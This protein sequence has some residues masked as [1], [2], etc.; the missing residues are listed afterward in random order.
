MT[1]TAGGT[2]A[3]GEEPILAR[4][5]EAGHDVGS[6][7]ELRGSGVKYP[8]AVPVLV[9]ALAVTAEKKALMEVVRALSVPWARTA[10]TG[11]LIDL[12]Q[13]ADDPTGLGLRW[14]VGNALD[15][16]WD[17]SFFDALVGL[18]RDRSYGR[19][20]EM[21]VLGLARSKRPAA[22]DVL[23]ELLDDPEVNGHAVKALAK[24]K[25]PRAKPGLERMTTDSRPW[26]RK[27][28][29]GALR[30]LG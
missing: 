19:A 10:A 3:P 23:I 7:A 24:L 21:V 30:K 1:L 17:D 25:L 15:V 28:A 12:F 20:R 2:P 11:P 18:V 22:G 6:L 8:K 27:A 9:D 26:V 16:V 13:R 5:R 29:E 14:A 4:L